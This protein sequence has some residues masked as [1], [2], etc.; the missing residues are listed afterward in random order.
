M[1][2]ERSKLELPSWLNQIAVF[3]TETTGLNL[4][5]SRIITAALHVINSDGEVLPQG[6]DWVLNPGIPIP[7][8]SSKVHGFYDKDVAN[9]QDATSGVSEIVSAIQELF[10]QGIPVVAY[11]ASYDFTILFYEAL[12][13]GVQPVK[14]GA[15]IDPLVID[16][17]VDKYRKGKRTLVSV[18]ERYGVPLL[19]AHTAA[20][21]AIAAGHVGY[22]I[23]RYY[24]ALDKPVAP[25]PNSLHE[26]HELQVKWADEIEDSYAAWRRQDMPNYRPAFGWPVK[27]LD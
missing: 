9:A 19:N 27:T 5:E 3:D 13:H 21:D 26:L 24:L 16:K 22:A 11:N 20:D 23:L 4:K 8:E 7:E 25:F 14:F 2:E 6:K 15:V 17:T 1:S 18:A 10:S 12:R